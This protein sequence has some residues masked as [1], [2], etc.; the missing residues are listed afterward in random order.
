MQTPDPGTLQRL[1]GEL[2]QALVRDR[3]FINK[4]DQL[5]RKCRFVASA[6]SERV[7]KALESEAEAG[8]NHT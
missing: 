2:E 1:M 5:L 3:E 4:C 7:N 6:M 8:S